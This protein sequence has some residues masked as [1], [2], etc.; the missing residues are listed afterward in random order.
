MV[1]EGRFCLSC[2]S[3]N[4]Q[5]NCS[6]LMSF[7]DVAVGAPGVRLNQQADQFGCHRGAVAIYVLHEREDAL[8]QCPV[9]HD[10]TVDVLFDYVAH[11]LEPARHSVV[12]NH[13][14][15]CSRCAGFTVSHVQ[16]W[17]ALDD[18]KGPVV[19]SDFNQRLLRRIYQTPA[20]PWYQG[21]FEFRSGLTLKL[22]I[23][24]MAACLVAS[25][26]FVFGYAAGQRGSGPSPV[27]HVD[28]RQA[29]QLEA[30]LDDLQLLRQ[31]DSVA[32]SDNE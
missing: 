14:A 5:G 20:I 15:T 30:A 12:E 29:D 19:S 2:R 10:E 23:P 32:P 25:T 31:L 4:Q 3:L 24:V 7:R 18:W 1:R 17:Q 8:M 28:G 9:E 26:G 27:L 22:A 6:N 21:L 13:V 11:R 16:V